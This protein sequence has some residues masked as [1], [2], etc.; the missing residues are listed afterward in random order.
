MKLSHQNSERKVNDQQVVTSSTSGKRTS[1][2]RPS[3]SEA[4]QEVLATRGDGES[5][6]LKKSSLSRQSN[7]SATVELPL[8]SKIFGRLIKNSN[9]L[10]PWQVAQQQIQSP[11]SFVA[12]RSRWDRGEAK[13]ELAADFYSH[14]CRGLPPGFDPT[15]APFGIPI[16][17]FLNKNHQVLIWFPQERPIEI[18]LEAQEGR[19]P[20]GY[21]LKMLFLIDPYTMPDD[22]QQS[23]AKVAVA[24]ALHLNAFGFPGVEKARKMIETLPDEQRKIGVQRV[25]NSAIE[26]HDLELASL[27]ITW[28]ADVNQW[29]GEPPEAPIYLAQRSG[30]KEITELL[31]AHGAVLDGQKNEPIWWVDPEADKM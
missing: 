8:P 24:A 15:D 31:L 12:Y 7:E 22:L 1:D 19:D 13:S 25:L 6:A 9:D 3:E 21:F 27:M 11:A 28:G 23:E 17:A 20:K 16:Y 26:F 5:D 18:D 2:A 29:S 30:K 10:K 4:D 14:H